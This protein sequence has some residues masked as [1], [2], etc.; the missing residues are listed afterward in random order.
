LSC[1]DI[2]APSRNDAYEWR[3]IVPTGAT[4]A[5]TLSFHWPKS[6]LP[7]RVWA[8]DSLNLVA[9]VES[10]LEQWEAVF[11]YGEFDAVR[12]SDSSTADVIVRVGSAVKGGFIRLA[13]ALA[14]ECEGGTDFNLPPGSN[15]LQMPIRIFVNPRFDPA[16]PG[17]AECMSLTTAH[18]LGHAIGIFAHSPNPAD[19]MYGDPTVTTPSRRDRSTAELAY[20]VD[21]TLAPGPR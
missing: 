2:A 17:V 4:T 11:L 7:V 20:H 14:P 1:A 5:D 13:A 6:R 12:V 19:L 9:D 21:V 16:T 3:R 10:G 15:Q 18:E 8:Q